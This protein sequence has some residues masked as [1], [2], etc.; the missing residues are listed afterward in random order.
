MKTEP[1]TRSRQQILHYVLSF[2]TGKIHGAMQAA[3]E[4]PRGQTFSSGFV[5]ES[6]ETPT[7]IGDLVLLTSAP[8]SKWT[9]GWLLQ[10]RDLNPGYPQWLIESIEDGELCWWGNVGLA[11]LHR[12]SLSPSWRWTDRQWAFRDRWIKVCRDEKD[13]YLYRPL[14]PVFGDGL[15]VTIGTRTMCG[16]DDISP[17][18]KF[19][20]WRKVT[21]AMM[22]Q[23]Y[24][25]CVAEHEAALPQRRAADQN[26]KAPPV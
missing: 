11:Y 23:C 8:S 1:K 3:Q 7:Q 24:D 13:A 22:G 4:Y 9:L 14:E 18:R 16:F 5:V 21:K 15:E 10:K 17:K 25:D 6:D 12:R 20:D 2:C 26:E 19:D